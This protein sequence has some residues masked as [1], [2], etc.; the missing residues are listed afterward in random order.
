MRFHQESFRP[1]RLYRNFYPSLI[2]GSIFI[3][4]SSL[5]ALNSGGDDLQTSM[6]IQSIEAA[7]FSVYSGLTFTKACQ[8]SFEGAGVGT[9]HSQGETK[10]KIAGCAQLFS[11]SKN[12]DAGE[13]FS[14][15]SNYLFRLGIKI[16]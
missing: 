14:S 1:E 3:G 16:S 9:L 12:S 10:K 15:F 2:A 6:N 4:L 13:K 11:H 8:R 5:G 7:K